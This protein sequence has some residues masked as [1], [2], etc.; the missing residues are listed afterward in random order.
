MIVSS[1]R[2][3]FAVRMKL[4]PKIGKPYRL[5]YSLF[6]LNPKERLWI[7]LILFILTIGSFAR[8]HHLSHPTEKVPLNTEETQ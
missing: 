3:L 8:W 6:Y 4:R 7:G 5:L 1:G 2:L